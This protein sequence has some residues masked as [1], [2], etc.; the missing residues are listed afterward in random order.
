MSERNIPLQ[1]ARLSRAT[2]ARRRLQWT[3]ALGSLALLLA[4]LVAGSDGWSLRG[5]TDAG[6][7]QQLIGPVRA[8][9]SL[10]AWL[11]GAL[12]GLAGGIAQGLFRNPLADPYLLGSA[13]GASLAVVLLLAAQSLWGEQI[14]ALMGAQLGSQVGAQVSAQTGTPAEPSAAYGWVSRALTAG[15]VLA[16]FTGALGGTLLTLVLARGAAQTTRLLLAG[17]VV[18]VILTAVN[19]LITTALPQALRTRQGFMLG[20]TG[21]LGWDAV[22]W[23]AAA[24]LVSGLVAWRLARTLDALVLGEDSALS[25]GLDL[26]RLRAG[27]VAALALATGV[28]V[29]LAGLI[30]FVGLV[31]PHL[32]RRFAPGP[33]RFSLMASAATGG[34]L[35]LGADILARSLMAP[36]EL[37]V[38]VLTALLGG[39]YL[40]RLLWRPPVGR[41]GGRA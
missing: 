20:Q 6:T 29:A 4:G 30:A 7:W 40:L 32:V 12:L 13:A 21:L 41:G 27:L 18:G 1:A 34:V 16:A 2:A 3:L 31:A 17:V 22:A 8:P 9:R 33:Q 15:S 23:M 35:L 38:G 19:D 37:P 36:L 26:P 28:S 5:L 10:G 24:L 14:G 39:G 25:L 11:A